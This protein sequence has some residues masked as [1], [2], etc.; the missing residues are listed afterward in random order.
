MFCKRE[1]VSLSYIMPIEKEGLAM[2]A[3]PP[4]A[5]ANAVLEEAQ[6]Q[7]KSLTIMQ[8]LKLVYIAHGWSLALF[9]RPLVSQPPQ[10]WEHGPVFPEVYRWFRKFGSGPISEYAS[11]PLGSMIRAELSPEQA[12]VISS[13]VKSYGDMH[14]FTLSNI[15]HQQGTPWSQSYQPGSSNLI[16]DGLIAA[17]YKELARARQASS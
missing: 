6:R 7:G 16:P 2:S 13:V 3:F 9:D 5:I 1:C 17:H 12:G 8:L 4:L 11:T 15:T 14:A 10:A